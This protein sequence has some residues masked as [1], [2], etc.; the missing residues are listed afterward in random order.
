[1]ASTDQEASSIMFLDIPP[2]IR[3]HIYRCLRVDERTISLTT[4]SQYLKGD[5]PVIRRDT[6]DS[7]S[8]RLDRDLDGCGWV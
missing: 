1:M 7:E 8:F 6:F 2:K 4:K 3:S 5:K